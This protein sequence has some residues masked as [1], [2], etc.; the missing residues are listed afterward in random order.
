MKTKQQ[1]SERNTYTP[2]NAAQVRSNCDLLLNSSEG[3]NS[4][5]DLKT[6]LNNPDE[7]LTA[8]KQA[9]QN[10]RVSVAYVLNMRGEP[11]MPT[12][13]RKARTL[14]KAGKA[15]VVKRTPFTIQLL[16]PTGETK[17]DVTLKMDTGYKNV[18]V[19]VVTKTKELFSAEFELRND[20]SKNIQERAMYRKLRR[21]RLWHRKP[22][23]L[24][25]KKSE[26]WLAPSVEHR[27]NS[28]LRIIKLIQAI[29]PANKIIIEIAKFDIQKIKNPNI[30]GVEYQN[31]DTKG[32][33]NI[34]EYLLYHANHKCQHCGGKSGDKILNVHHV[35]PRANGGTDT[36][37]NLIVLCETCHKNYHNGKITLKIK[38]S[39]EYKAE[40]IMNII[41]FKLFNI[42]K[43]LYNNVQYTYGY[44]TKCKRI[45]LNLQKTHY[46][47]AFC[48]DDDFNHNQKRNNIIY[49]CKFVRKQNRSLFKSN[50]LKGGKLK[51]NTIKQINN[52]NRFDKVEYSKQECFVH[53]LRTSGYF[54]LRDI[55]NNKVHTSVNNKKLKLLE[56]AKTLL[57]QNT[58]FHPTIEIVGIQA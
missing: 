21:S 19:S 51:R 46:N 41:R 4:V 45:E 33:Y 23:F 1:L 48:I 31:G 12:S 43:E 56:K 42:L 49:K 36:V 55:Y 35:K 15:K 18:G 52:F 22:R 24:N 17:Q 3:R 54:E 16:Y 14:L 53:G 8:T 34:R 29:L 28:H 57:I 39:K 11:L 40:T 2:T 27:L 9:E 10:L 47:D 20:V 5:A 26:N 30:S 58:S 13:P 37:D 44:L 6:S 50:L 25:R 32:F 38:R 7:Q